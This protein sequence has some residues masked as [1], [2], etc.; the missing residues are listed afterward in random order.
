[1]N[2]RLA[3]EVCEALCCGACRCVPALS[4]L[5][6]LACEHGA[7]EV[8]AQSAQ[9]IHDTLGHHLLGG[10]GQRLGQSFLQKQLVLKRHVREV[11]IDFDTQQNG[12]RKGKEERGR[13][14]LQL[15]TGVGSKTAMS[16]EEEQRRRKRRKRE[17]K[18]RKKKK[19]EKEN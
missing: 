7:H 1:M 11:P 6:V 14:S 2:E 5:I 18:K 15:R 8:L 16:L 4:V 9:F 12:E 13:Q 19:R 17:K 3:N 10:G